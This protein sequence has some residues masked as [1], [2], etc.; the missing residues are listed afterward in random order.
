MYCTS[1]TTIRLFRLH[2]VYS[3]YQLM[4]MM[5]M[6]IEGKRE[7][8]VI[9]AIELYT[10]VR[11]CCT[12]W[13]IDPKLCPCIYPE[14]IGL[15]MLYSRLQTK[16]Q[17]AAGIPASF[18]LLS[19]TYKIPLFKNKTKN[20]SLLG[21]KMRRWIAY[22]SILHSWKY[23]FFSRR[24]LLENIFAK[25][26]NKGKCIYIE[27]EN[28]IFTLSELLQFHHLHPPTSWCVYQWYAEIS[29]LP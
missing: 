1:I 22:L 19:F 13:R 9:W 6:M 28:L 26:K 20:N 4:M 7:I 21:L 27:I 14:W 18:L 11:H 29:I 10:A 8:G 12:Y 16:E 17:R 5:I 25:N 15:M 24:R 23:Y 3:H 2:M